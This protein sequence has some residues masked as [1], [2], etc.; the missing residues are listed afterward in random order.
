[1]LAASSHYGEKNGC[2][3]GLGLIRHLC[4]LECGLKVEATR[5][6]WQMKAGVERGDAASGGT[7][8]DQSFEQD[9]SVKHFNFLT[10]S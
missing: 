2:A 9:H 3:V 1:V 7:M 5:P 8:P 4:C 6:R 10:H